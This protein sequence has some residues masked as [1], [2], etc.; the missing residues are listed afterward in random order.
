MANANSNCRCSN[1]EIKLEK[2]R[3][4]PPEGVSGWL[5]SVSLKAKISLA[6]SLT[7]GSIGFP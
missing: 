6:P 2:K 7:A 3:P 5:V 4:I 1:V